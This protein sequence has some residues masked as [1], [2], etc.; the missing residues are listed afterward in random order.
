MSLGPPYPKLVFIMFSVIA[1][2][3]G[4]VRITR[5]GTGNRLCA[6]IAL[7]SSWVHDAKVTG[8]N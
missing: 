8:L 3:L 5:P 1:V 6:V 2:V 7:C 4:I